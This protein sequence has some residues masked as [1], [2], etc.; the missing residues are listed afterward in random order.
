MSKTERSEPP[1]PAV[2]LP[3]ERGVGRPVPERD[4]DLIAAAAIACGLDKGASEWSGVDADGTHWRDVSH[5]G[6]GTRIARWNPLRD[7]G[8]ALRLLVK[9]RLS[10]MLGSPGDEK[11]VV[12]VSAEDGGDDCA[13]VRRAIVRAAAALSA[14]KPPNAQHNRPASAGP[15]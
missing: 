2:G 13:A 1:A 8:D 10:V 5:G 15:G 9:L 3:V 14:H 11:P 6:D 7:D 12:Q 4:H